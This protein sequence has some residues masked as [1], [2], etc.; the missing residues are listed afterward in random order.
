MS[1]PTCRSVEEAQQGHDAVRAKI[2]AEITD[3]RERCARGDTSNPP[4]RTPGEDPTEDPSWFT[5][6]EQT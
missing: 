4:F 5:P 3:Y 6:E 1:F 2:W